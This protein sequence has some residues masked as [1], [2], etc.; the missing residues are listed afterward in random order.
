M[1]VTRIHPNLCEQEF[2][3]ALRA[4]GLEFLVEFE[5]LFITIDM[6]EDDRAVDL[7]GQDGFVTFRDPVEDGEALVV[8]LERFVVAIPLE[9]GVAEVDPQLREV[10]VVACVFEQTSRFGR[11]L[12]EGFRTLAGRADQGAS[13]FAA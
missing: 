9:T 8:C 5:R 11:E 6:T 12:F 7:D 3:L 1:D 2:E 13:A 10:E 4:L